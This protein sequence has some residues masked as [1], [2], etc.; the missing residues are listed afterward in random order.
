MDQLQAYITLL[1][2]AAAETATLAAAVWLRYRKERGALPFVL[3]MIGVALW[4]AAYAVELSTPTLAGK[5]LAARIEYFGIVSVPVF[6]LIFVL[7]YTGRDSW[8]TLRNLILLA[9]VPLASLL[10]VWTNELHTLFYRSVSIATEQG[11][12]HFEP[13]Y[14]PWFWIHTAYSYLMLLMA[15]ILLTRSL[16]KFPQLYRGQAATLMIGVLAPVIGNIVYVFGF[17][18]FGRLD[19]TPFAFTVTGLGFALSIVSYR[20]MDLVPAARDAVIEGMRDAIIVLDGYDR[21]VDINPA[22]ERI[23][24]TTRDQALGK[25]F[26]EILPEQRE[27]IEMFQDVEEIHT[28]I[29]VAAGTDDRRAFDMSIT[30]LKEKDR[31]AGRLVMLHDITVQK[32]AEEN[33]ANAHEHALEALRIKSRILE[34]VSRDFRSPLNSI[35]GYSDMLVRQIHGPITDSQSGQITRIL[36]NANELAELVN[37]LLEQARLEDGEITLNLARFKPSALLDDLKERLGS[38][39][40]DKGLALSFEVADDLQNEMVYG[41]QARLVQTAGNITANAVKFTDK[42]SVQVQLFKRGQDR[43]GIEVKDTGP[44]MSQDVL[45]HIFEPFWQANGNTTLDQRGVGL[46][47][48]IARQLTL[49]MSGEIEVESKVGQGTTF[50]VLLPLKTAR[51]RHLGKSDTSLSGNSD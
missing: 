5:L 50:R 28:Q 35:I 29:D 51:E 27:L 9:V 19:L 32:K 42:G 40:A 33:L 16:I 11:I 37:A 13:V 47:L 30:P 1:A 18:P 34:I 45:A 48:S 20:L 46:G 7:A 24:L 38:Q 4:S 2:V 49:M 31:T 21:I 43:W 39:A 6:F 10:L 17:S 41:D 23:T 15:L 26:I 25:R 3:L 8:L 12:Q 36:S 14:G 22:A 44:G